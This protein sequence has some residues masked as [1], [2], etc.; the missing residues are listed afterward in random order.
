M[1][2]A[3]PARQLAREIECNV[4]HV[5]CLTGADLHLAQGQR[6]NQFDMAVERNAMFSFW[7]EHSSDTTVEEMFLDSRGKEISEIEQPE[8][9]NMLPNYEGKRVLELGA[10]IGRYTGKIAEKASHVT[11][12]DFME[13]FVQKNRKV[14]GKYSNIEF[15]CADV[16]QLERKV[17]S[18]DI[19]FSNWLFM[20]LGDQEIH[21]LLNKMLLSV[22][23]LLI[24]Y[25]WL[26]YCLVL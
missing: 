1:D 19:I 3:Y 24:D 20:Y 17:D 23:F 10:G 16:T 7:K 8:I 4:Y 22:H 25:R 2:L 12:V 6:W 15:L 26:D 21:K 13:S 5:V 11:A 9:L 14:N 18:Y